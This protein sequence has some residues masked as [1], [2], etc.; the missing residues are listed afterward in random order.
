M[1]AEQADLTRGQRAIAPVTR[2]DRDAPT[3][4]G[5]PW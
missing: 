2:Q 1:Y 4:L 5:A 3:L